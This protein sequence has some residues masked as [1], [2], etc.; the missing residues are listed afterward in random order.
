MPRRPAAPC[1]SS[2]AVAPG[3]HPGHVRLIPAERKREVNPGCSGEAG[4]DDPV[5]V[6]EVRFP[7]QRN[8]IGDVPGMRIAPHVE[9]RLSEARL[10][11]EEGV[12]RGYQVLGVAGPL[13]RPHPHQAVSSDVDLFYDLHFSA[14]ARPLHVHPV[15]TSEERG[16]R[17]FDLMAILDRPLPVD[18]AEN[19]I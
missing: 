4:I 12:R 3:I 17:P 19:R 8:R 14:E 10:L 15:A 1:P 5:L 16:L 18:L 13:P 7:F 11:L 2:V 6:G 9:M